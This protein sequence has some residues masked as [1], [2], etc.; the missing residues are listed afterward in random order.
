ML[1]SY[2]VL[3]TKHF[4]FIGTIWEAESMGSQVKNICKEKFFLQTVH[5]NWEV[6]NH[7]NYKM[8]TTITDTNNV[9]L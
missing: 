7:Q 2:G 4:I 9:E 5:I 3:K 1:Q 6:Q 8:Y